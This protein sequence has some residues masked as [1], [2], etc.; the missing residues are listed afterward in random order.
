MW[1][2]IHKNIVL[3]AVSI[4]RCPLALKN[5]DSKVD[6]ILL[7]SEAGSVFLRTTLWPS[8]RTPTAKCVYRR[9]TFVAGMTHRNE[10][11]SE[12]SLEKA[13]SSSGGT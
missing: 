6:T 3:S 13:C 8:T 11:V 5:G 10:K 9:H 2:I 1:L 4:D 12:P 7:G